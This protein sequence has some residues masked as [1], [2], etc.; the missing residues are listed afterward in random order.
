VEMKVGWTS[1]DFAEAKG[2]HEEG[3]SCEVNHIED[4]VISY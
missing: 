4:T 2:C 1:H 3:S